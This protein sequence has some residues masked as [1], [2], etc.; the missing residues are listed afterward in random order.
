[1]KKVLALDVAYAHIG[2]AVI[3]PYRSKDTI[4]AAGCIEN[5]SEPKKKKEV[6]AASLR[7]ERISRL[8]LELRDIYREYEPDCLVAELPHGGGKSNTA[9]ASM[10]MGTAIVS[11]LVAQFDIPAEWTTPTE[12]KVAMCRKKTANKVEMQMTA[13]DKYSEL[14]TIVPVSKTSKTGRPG[15]FEH[16]ADAIAA[17]LAAR[18][19]ALIRLLADANTGCAGG[20]LF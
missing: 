10:A 6:R 8:Y 15:W 1:M 2:W 11:C 4:V 7:V 16:S 5:K 19:S 9:V 17:Y 14:R 13:L 20:T 12:G 18:R 3:E